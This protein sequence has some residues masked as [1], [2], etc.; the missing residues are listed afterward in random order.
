MT[1][2]R[3]GAGWRFDPPPPVLY[4]YRSLA[5]PAREFTRDIIV[6]HRLWFSAAAAFNDPFDSFP[7][8]SLDGTPEQYAAYVRYVVTK[9]QP[10]ASPSEHE[11]TIV[12]LM[13]L[14]PQA[15]FE[16]M[17]DAGANHLQSLSLCC[18]SAVNNQVLMW[19]HYADAHAGL[20][21]RFRTRPGSTNIP[22]L[23]YR[24]SYAAD[25]PVVNRVTGTD[26]YAGLFDA[27]LV[28]ADFWAYEQE[29]RLFRQDVLGGPGHEAFG[30][31]RL[32][33]II[34]GARCGAESR[35]MVREW[36]QERG[37]PVEF[38]EAA[39]DQHRFRLAIRQV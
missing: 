31:E 3:P 10:T 19:S 11:R 6:N 1:L 24:V 9:A 15:I 22:D 14:S 28:K 37:M 13:S 20:C 5:G 30:P 16:M 29:H 2:D 33:A 8:L 17:Q 25:R 12:G 32:D 23:A 39:P 36:V 38:L 34:F 35:A 26:D 21:L 7:V 4:K 18:L 27:M